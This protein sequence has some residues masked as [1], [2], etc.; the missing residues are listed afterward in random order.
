MVKVEYKRSCLRRISTLKISFAQ[1]VW[2][3]SFEFWQPCLRGTS[4]FGIPKFG[5]IFS[6]SYYLVTLKISC[7]QLKD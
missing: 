7:A 6:F 5:Q 1:S 4:D 2:L 3:K